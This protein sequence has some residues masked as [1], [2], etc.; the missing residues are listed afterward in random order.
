MYKCT[1]CENEEEKEREIICWKC[2]IGEMVF[3]RLERKENESF[4]DF[5]RRTLDYYRTVFADM[6]N[7]Q[8]NRRYGNGNTGYKVPV[9]P[10]IQFDKPPSGVVL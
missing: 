6:I 3:K 7:G 10:F 5:V 2:G 4:D 1:H 8:C 9:E